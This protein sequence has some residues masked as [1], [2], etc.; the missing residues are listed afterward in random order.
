MSTVYLHVGATKTGTTF[1]QNILTRNRSLLRERGVLWPGRRWADQVRATND[2]LGRRV[3][4]GAPDASGAWDRLA[5]EIRGFDGRAAIVSM[6]FLSFATPEAARRAVD[7]LAPHDVRVVITARDLQRVIPAIWQESVQNGHTLAYR[8]YLDALTQSEYAGP[9]VGVR[10]AFWGQQDIARVLHTWG[11]AVDRQ[12]CSLVTVPAPGA[13]RGLLWSRFCEATTLDPVGLRPGSSGN[14]SLGATSA[15]LM[16]RATVRAKE[17]DAN[18]ATLQVL[19][20]R[21][22]KRALARRRGE[23][24]TLILPPA[25]AEW[26]GRQQRTLVDAIREFDPVIVGT[27][28]DLLYAAAPGAPAPAPTDGQVVAPAH[29]PAAELL[30]AALD[31]IVALSEDL[32]RRAAGSDPDD[33][34]TDTD[35]DDGGA[36]TPP[37]P[38]SLGERDVVGPS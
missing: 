1:V 15:E 20:W 33:T 14:E 22:A 35:A 18:W 10:A 29:V 23:E 24:P 38:R 2:L 31:A 27:L 9:R 17:G 3:G 4:R 32:G 28:D 5:A 26:T 12:S 7:S 25:Y 36:D 19:K 6:E 37:T 11:S 13:D 30:D 16:R 8:A 21:T 34:D